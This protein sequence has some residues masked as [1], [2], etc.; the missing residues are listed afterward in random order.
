MDK[1][2]FR[3]EVTAL[4]LLVTVSIIKQ[5]KAWEAWVA[6]WLGICLHLWS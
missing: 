1:E 5:D 2:I 4:Q 3:R 6:Q